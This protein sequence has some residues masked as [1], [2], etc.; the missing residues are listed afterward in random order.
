MT[1]DRHLLAGA[2][3][4]FAEVSICHPLDTIKTRL[5]LS[6][7]RNSIYSLVVNM[8]RRE[9]PLAFYKGYTAVAL[10]IVPKTAF[11]FS[12]FNHFR[13]R[14]AI[15]E[16]PSRKLNSNIINFFSG[17]TTGLLEALLIVNPVDVCKIRMQ[18]QRHSL[19]DPEAMYKR[20]YSNVLQTG[21]SIV[22][23]EGIRGLYRGLVPTLIR[24]GS[25]QSINFTGYH[26]LKN[27][28]QERNASSKST[29]QKNISPYQQFI[30][31]VMSSSIS[32]LLNTPIDVVKTRIQN[33]S[34]R[35]DG[36][37]DCLRRVYQNEGIVALWKGCF[38][39]I[40]RL[41]PG[42]GIT[43]MTYEYILQI[44]SDTS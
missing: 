35:Y 20:K 40:F 30:I 18:A 37:I 11:R 21:Y 5:Q 31:G 28:I 36:M 33:K 29:C 17:L 41:A 8:I 15:M 44:T 12:C 1:G 43:F 6:Q 3:A 23:E 32:P 25:N 10:G 42:Q 39:R 14:L 22:K 24:Q 38:P 19:A 26:Y 34:R 27:K 13:S 2:L 16:S 9:S 7:R 4:G